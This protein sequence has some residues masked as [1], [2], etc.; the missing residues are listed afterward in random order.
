MR[1]WRNWN[2]HALLV[3]MYNGI[4]ALQNTFADIQNVN[5]ELSYDPG[6]PLLSISKGNEIKSTQKLPHPHPHGCSQQHCS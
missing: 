6:V 3:R 4:V 2:P 5:T 1:I